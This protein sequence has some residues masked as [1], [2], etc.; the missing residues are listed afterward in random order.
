VIAPVD[1]QLFERGHIYVAVPDHH[2]LLRPGS[3]LLVRRGP[4]ENR[5]RPAINALFRSAA[6]AYGARP[7]ARTG[8]KSCKPRSAFAD[9][10]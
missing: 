7:F 3:Q 6:I 5:T 4:H 1:G 9:R 2:L 10:H 8:L